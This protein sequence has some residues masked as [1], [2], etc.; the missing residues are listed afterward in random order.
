MKWKRLAGAVSAGG[1]SW[2]FAT[3]LRLPQTWPAVSGKPYAVINTATPTMTSRVAQRHR[4]E[5]GRNSPTFGSLRWQSTGVSAQH[6]PGLHITF[7]WAGNRGGRARRPPFASRKR[8]SRRC[9]GAHFAD[10]AGSGHRLGPYVAGIVDLHKALAT[11]RRGSK[12]RPNS[13][14]GKIALTPAP[15][16]AIKLSLE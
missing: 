16:N 12:P 13:V 1:V 7:R 8:A 11:Q 6:G 5:P 4:A 14:S 15:A 9:L 10:R 3:S 2:T